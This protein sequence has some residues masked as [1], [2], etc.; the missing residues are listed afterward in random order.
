M[1]VCVRACGWKTPPI[2]SHTNIREDKDENL[3]LSS[4]PPYFSPRAYEGSRHSNMDVPLLSSGD[5]FRFDAQEERGGQGLAATCHALSPSLFVCV[6]RASR[7][8]FSPSTYRERARSNPRKAV[9]KAKGEGEDQRTHDMDQSKVQLTVCNMQYFFA[10]LPLASLFS[11]VR[12]SS[13]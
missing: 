8:I 2:I 10:C 6:L 7:C 11:F 9:H 1:C 5:K 4:A 12:C 13:Y 3:L